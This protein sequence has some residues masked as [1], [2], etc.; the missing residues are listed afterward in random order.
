MMPNKTLSL[1]KARSVYER[2][3]IRSRSLGDTGP[4]RILL[5][6]ESRRDTQHYYA[7]NSNGM[8]WTQFREVAREFPYLHL[9]NN[10]ARRIVSNNGK[11]R[12][13]VE[14]IPV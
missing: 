13:R 7:A 12:G 6:P 1:P 5:R 14:I 3:E 11:L 4:F 8:F 2:E 10:V 9:A